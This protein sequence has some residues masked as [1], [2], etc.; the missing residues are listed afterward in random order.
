MFLPEHRR[1][2]ASAYRAVFPYPLAAATALVV[3][4]L[5]PILL[6]SLQIN[7]NNKFSPFDEAAHLDYVERLSQGNVPRQGEKMLE[8][9]MRAIACNGYQGQD[10]DH[11]PSCDS[12]RG[13][14]PDVMK[15]TQHEAIQ[16]PTYYA[17]TAPLRWTAHNILGFDNDLRA[18]RTT[19]IAWLVLGLVLLWI[20]GRIMAMSPLVLGS[21]ILILTT[22]PAVL[23]FSGTVSN[24]VTAIFSAGLVAMVGALAYR[25]VGGRWQIAG[26]FVAGFFAAALK[27]TNLLVVLVVAL[28]LGIA[29]INR[30]SADEDWASVSRRWLRSGGVLLLGGLIAAL[31]WTA[32]HD[33]I[34]LIAVADDPAFDALRNGSRSPGAIISAGVSILWLLTGDPGTVVLASLSPATM[35]QDVLD[36]FYALLACLPIVGGLVALFVSPRRWPHLLGLV[37][38]AVLCV[39][40]MALA[41]GFVLLYDQDPVAPAR[42]GLSLIPLLMLAFSG[43]LTGRRAQWATAAF[44]IALCLTTLLV[45]II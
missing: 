1:S 28:L 16:P 41:L 12:S 22:S 42:Y 3:C 26:L 5:I 11:L 39:G 13:S 17:L 32:I 38:L 23:Y 9:S 40:G 36:P 18:T 37:S 14:W 19:S 2:F 25:R 7:S 21:A 20:A 27:N 6:V 43:S 10:F 15:W 44:A 35:D 29:A 24:D 33:H 30:R 45:M 31:L 8:S 4:V 34:A